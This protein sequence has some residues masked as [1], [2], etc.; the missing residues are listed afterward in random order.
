VTTPSLRLGVETILLAAAVAAVAALSAIPGRG[1][2]TGGGIAARAA[3]AGP[4]PPPP[5]GAFVLAQENGADGV[6]LSVRVGGSKLEL[7]GT[8]LD[9]TGLGV[10]GLT[11]SFTIDAGDGKTSTLRSSPCGAGCYGGTAVVRGRPA[12]VT[13]RLSGREK[14]SQVRFAMPDLWPPTPAAALI[15]RTAGT[16]KQLRTLVTNERLGSDAKHVLHTIYRDVAP[17]RLEYTV[18]G[19][20]QSIIVGSRRW[21]RQPGGPWKSSQQQPI[22]VPSPAWGAS[23]KVTNAFLLGTALVAGRRSWVVSF[24]TPT[25]PAWFTIW[26]D[27]RSLRTVELRMTAAAHFMHHVYSGFNQSLRVEAP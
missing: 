24:A 2:S 6:A 13:V 4:P 25:V 7:T 22:T 23:T 21:D 3:G 18:E 16:I 14:S 11:V 19:V 1:T 17:N 12:A 5:T 10:S 20:G 27:S 8:V 9:Q 15:R 26:I